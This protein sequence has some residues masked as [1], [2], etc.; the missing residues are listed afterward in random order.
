MT[1]LFQR[2]N[3]TADSTRLVSAVFLGFAPSLIGWALLE[4]MARCF[5]AL[6]SAQLPLIAA[7]IPIT[8]N[9]AVTSVLRTRGALA[10]PA[11]L[12]WGASIGLMMGFAALF[13]MIHVRRKAV[14]LKPALVEF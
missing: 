3:F 11:T 10:N 12:G 13:T 8:V 5:F 1:L 9:L 7:F 4:L 14:D 2:G 6:N